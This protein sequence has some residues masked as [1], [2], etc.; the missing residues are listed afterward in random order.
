M[1]KFLLRR[2]ANYAI[3]VAVAYTKIGFMN[4]PS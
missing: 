4:S 1:A 3:L 2:L